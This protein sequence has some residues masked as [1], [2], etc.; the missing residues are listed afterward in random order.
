MVCIDILNLSPVRPSPNWSLLP[1]AHGSC[2]LLEPSIGLF[3]ISLGD[4]CCGVR[5]K[6]GEG[7]LDLFL[8]VWYEYWRCHEREMI[9]ETG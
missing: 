8:Q 1:W 3:V 6:S 9:V 4:V 5:A 2:Y 7:N